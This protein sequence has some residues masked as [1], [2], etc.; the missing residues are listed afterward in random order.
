[1]VHGAAYPEGKTG[2]ERQETVFGVEE[3]GEVGGKV[4][5]SRFGE[6]EAG[7]ERA[8]E[9][10]TGHPVWE[11]DRRVEVKAD[12]PSATDAPI[13]LLSQ[14]HLFWFPSEAFQ[15]EGHPA[16]THPVSQT[17]QRASG[18][19]SEESKEN[20]SQEIYHHQSPVNADDHEA[21]GY[22]DP[23]REDY[24]DQD[25]DHHNDQDD[26]DS[27]QE[28]DDHQVKH[29]ITVHRDD[30]DRRGHH[31]DDHH[32]EHYDMGEHEE[33]RG[34]TRYGSQEV[35]DQDDAYDEHE[36]YEDQRDITDDHEDDDQE[37]PDG[38]RENPD[39]DDQDD[40][41]DH[42][43]GQ[44]H[45]DHDDHEDS[46]EHHDHDGDNDDHFDGHDDLDDPEH[47]DHDSYE[48][49]D[50]HEDIDGRQH[51]VIFSVARD[52]HQNISQATEGGK[53]STDESWLDGYPVNAAE[54]ENGDTA[55][56][57]TGL[58]GRGMET[59]T[60]LPASPT[61]EPRLDQEEEMWAGFIPTDDS[62]Q[63]HSQPSDSDTQAAPTQSWLDAL[64]EHPLVDHNPAPPVHDRGSQVVEHTVHNLPGESGQREGEIGEAICTGKGCPPATPSSKG[65]KVATIIVV[66]CLIVIAVLLGVWCYRRQQQ[67][68]SVYEMN[69]KGQSQARPNQQ[70]EM[71][72]K[73]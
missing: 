38:S 56:E 27:H 50:S 63:E 25:D 35:D 59:A 33:E 11:E 45:Y 18:V 70:M 24:D 8:V 43:D 52:E 34:R 1:M 31:D 32:D 15:G 67:K 9:D 65:P 49:H 2:Q 64:T 53:A 28:E 30:L 22:D 48:H 6:E 20:E 72:Q 7:E 47:D 21:P 19:Q 13:S 54:S 26:R 12:V 46:R 5:G 62:S 4:A 66:V 57:R 44:E 29:H 14:K 41:D 10:F 23:D 71:Q 39:Q 3:K 51:H 55:T 61:K 40:H 37:H 36:S 60:G 42:D 17:T 73:V 58:E 69:G 16:S 68:S